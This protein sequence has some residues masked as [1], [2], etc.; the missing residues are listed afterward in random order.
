[1]ATT[2][3]TAL[4]ETQSTLNVAPLVG[5]THPWAAVLPSFTRACVEVLV[6]ALATPPADA[7]ATLMVAAEA[8]SEPSI[9]TARRPVIGTRRMTPPLEKARPTSWAMG[10]PDRES[11]ISVATPRAPPHEQRRVM[12]NLARA[13]AASLVRNTGPRKAIASPHE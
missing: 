4:A 8:G 3:L 1:M 2:R 13:V 12:A 10:G 6:E 5:T 9:A 7:S 11:C